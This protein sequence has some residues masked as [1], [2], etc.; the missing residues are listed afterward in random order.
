M[1]SI[2]HGAETQFRHESAFRERERA[3]LA[4]IRERK[5]YLAEHRAPA[6]APR[7]VAPWPRPIGVA[8]CFEAACAVA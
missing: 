2:V 4:A 6:R 8:S 5:A 3:V 1:L 7:Q